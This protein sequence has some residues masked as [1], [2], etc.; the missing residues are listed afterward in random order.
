MSYP[1]ENPP[2]GEVLGCFGWCLGVFWE[3][4]R[5]KNIEMYKTQSLKIILKQFFFYFFFV[6]YRGETTAGPPGTDG[7]TKI[8]LKNLILSIFSLFFPP[9]SLPP[10]TSLGYLI[11]NF[12]LFPKEITLM[13]FYGN[14]PK[15]VVISSNEAATGFLGGS[16]GP[17]KGIIGN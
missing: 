5:G 11:G 17:L 9:T 16:V 13:T 4:F 6:F 2:L 1:E 12:L 15:V 3:V 7:R 14:F 8:A 10:L